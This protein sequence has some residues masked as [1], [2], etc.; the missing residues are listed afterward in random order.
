MVMPGQAGAQG[1]HVV[2]RGTRV[3]EVVYITRPPGGGIQPGMTGPTWHG[4]PEYAKEW[5]GRLWAAVKRWIAGGNRLRICDILVVID[6]PVPPHHELTI[7][8]PLKSNSRPSLTGP[9]TI[10]CAAWR[11]RTS[12]DG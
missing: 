5:V 10:C 9:L 7:V 12:L 3:S 8:I 6:V 2:V 1:H 11:C 4:L